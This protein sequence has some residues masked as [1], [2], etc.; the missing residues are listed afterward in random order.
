[1]SKGQPSRIL[2]TKLSNY[3][4]LKIKN[5]LKSIE[6]TAGFS[7]DFFISSKKVLNTSAEPFTTRAKLAPEKGGARRKIS[8]FFRKTSIDRL[9]SVLTNV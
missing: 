1:M 3:F 2:A 9:V 4:F 8:E 5:A 7:A 6:K